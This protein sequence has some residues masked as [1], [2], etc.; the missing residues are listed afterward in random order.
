MFI[1]TN[2]IPFPSL[3]SISCLKS[4]AQL[5]ILKVFYGFLFF[6]LY[7]ND[8]IWPEKKMR[9]ASIFPRSLAGWGLL[10]NLHEKNKEIIVRNSPIF[11][12][13]GSP[14]PVF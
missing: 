3:I 13:V 12:P 8:G 4:V 5:S 6:F 11:F 14:I 1:N 9:R 10:Y 7:F 2:S